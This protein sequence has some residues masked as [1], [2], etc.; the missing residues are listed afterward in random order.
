MTAS[1]CARTLTD[2]L[3]TALVPAFIPVAALRWTDRCEGSRVVP[4]A[5]RSTTRRSL[6]SPPHARPARPPPLPPQRTQSRCRPH[7]PRPRV[8]P[9][10]RRC[11]ARGGVRRRGRLTLPDLSGSVARE[12]CLSQQGSFPR[13]LARAGALGALVAIIVARTG[14]E[15]PV[16][17]YCSASARLASRFRRAGQNLRCRPQARRWLPLELTH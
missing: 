3:G 14:G 5:V 4:W 9:T 17:L 16:C 12:V 13:L 7:R 8:S 10:I 2:A 6:A 15:A 1:L 11:P